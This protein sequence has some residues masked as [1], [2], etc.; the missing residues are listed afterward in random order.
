MHTWPPAFSFNVNDIS[1]VISD[2]SNPVLC[3]DDTSLIITNSN[4]QMFKKNI[5]SAIL[6]LNRWLNSNQI[7]LN[8]EKL[9]F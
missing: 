2:I 3:A 7:L 1:H 5:N 6:Q 4:S 9:V 8:L